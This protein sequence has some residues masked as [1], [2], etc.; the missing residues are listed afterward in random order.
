MKSGITFYLRTAVCWF[1]AVTIACASSSQKAEVQAAPPW[2]QNLEQA[3]PSRE[4][5]AVTA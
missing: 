1:L 2:V 4:W 5:V 3:Y